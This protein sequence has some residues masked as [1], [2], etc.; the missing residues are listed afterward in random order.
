MYEIKER[1]YY[2]LHPPSACA[3]VATYFPP[4]AFNNNP[5]PPPSVTRYPPSTPLSVTRYP[6]SSP[7]LI[8]LSPPPPRPPPQPPSP[9]SADAGSSSYLVASSSTGA[10]LAVAASSSSTGR[11]FTSSDY[12]A[13]WV[14]QA[15]AFHTYS[16]YTAISMSDDGSR[17]VAST[18]SNFG[19]GGRNNALYTSNDFGATWRLGELVNPP[20][21]AWTGVATINGVAISGDGSHITACAV[22]FFNSSYTS[23]AGVWISTDGGT[24]YALS[25]APAGLKWAGVKMS[26][27]GMSIV[28][29]SEAATSEG[30][31]PPAVKSSAGFVHTSSD[32]GVTWQRR[33]VNGSTPV[34][35]WSAGTIS[36]D[37]AIMHAVPAVGSYF[38]SSTDGGNSWVQKPIP[39]WTILGYAFGASA[40]G[41]KLVMTVRSDTYTSA[42]SGAAGSWVKS[43]TLPDITYWSSM[44][45]SSDLTHLVAA[46]VYGDGKGAYVSGDSGVTWKKVRFPA[47][48]PPPPPP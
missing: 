9:P 42:S 33:Q 48:S 15:G 46:A 29:A 3:G 40:D 30:Y 24:T 39:D 22:P 45:A 11:L 1:S 12:G 5:S 13:S 32:G 28:A 20:G 26:K 7:P 25:A 27:S 10:R 17:I 16:P 47:S 19:Y 43:S 23:P 31:D 18:G 41:T 34:Q 14:E 44:A 4:S 36:S 38:F 37:G 21:T 6:P 8:S 35:Y 2:A